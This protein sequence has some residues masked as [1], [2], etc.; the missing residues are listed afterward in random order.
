M[1]YFILA[2]HIILLTD[3]IVDAVK[4]VKVRNFYKKYVSAPTKKKKQEVL[5]HV[6]ILKSLLIGA[7]VFSTTVL[8]ANNMIQT[9]RD[10]NLVPSINMILITIVQLIY[11]RFDRNTH[12][13]DWLPFGP[14]TINE[15]NFYRRKIKNAFREIVVFPK[16]DNGNINKWTMKSAELMFTYSMVKAMQQIDE[17][18]NTEYYEKKLS[19]KFKENFDAL[20]K[21]VFEE[22]SKTM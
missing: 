21:Q 12:F 6:C 3:L 18:P 11:Y 1:F 17:I 7:M 15:V 20:T 22:T 19:E 13:I 10:P 14:S 9:E 4:Y 16:T 5:T 8:V 2:I